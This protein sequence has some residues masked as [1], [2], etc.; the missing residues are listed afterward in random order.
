VASAV[1]C[2]RWS[3]DLV[4]SLLLIASQIK[5]LKLWGPF[6]FHAK[7]HKELLA[8]VFDWCKERYADFAVKC[9]VLEEAQ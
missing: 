9:P 7:F 6:H 4:F 5:V 8:I 3:S 2:L 1:M